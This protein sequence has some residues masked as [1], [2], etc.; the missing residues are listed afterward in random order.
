MDTI[1]F[2][3]RVITPMFLAGADGQTPELRAPSIKG[4]MR[5]WWRALNGH[6]GEKEMRLAEE[7]LFGGVLKDG[8]KRSKVTVMVSQQN[9]KTGSLPRSSSDK[10]KNPG[11]HYLWYTIPMNN[12]RPG[13]WEGGFSVQLSSFD[14]NALE[15]VSLAFWTLANFGGLGTRARRGAGCFKIEQIHTNTTQNSFEYIQSP[16]EAIGDYIRRN[17]SKLAQQFGFVKNFESATLTPFPMF[18][19]VQIHLLQEGET[20]ALLALEKIGYSYQQFRQRLQPDYNGVKDYIISGS[21][22]R[23]VKRAEFGLPLSFRFSSLGSAGADIKTSRK[24]I[25]RS[26]SSMMIHVNEAGGRYYV[27]ITNFASDLLPEN[28]NLKVVTPRRNPQD[29]SPDRPAYVNQPYQ[30][31]KETFL[32]TLK[33]DIL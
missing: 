22:P 21:T 18:K 14:R 33:A 6:K 26:A 1:T 15:E 4:A 13:I 5:F 30:G 2:H 12:D 23:Q 19:N 20:S 17:V 9:V 27:V 29:Y 7:Y 3:C 31:I 8:A 11:I 16:K 28:V 32:A 25:D 10:E 24:D